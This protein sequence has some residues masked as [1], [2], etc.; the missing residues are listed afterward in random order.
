M[1]EEK[2]DSWLLS[3]YERWSC[4]AMK[5]ELFLADLMMLPFWK[6]LFIDRKISD[7]LKQIVKENP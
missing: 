7:Y 2:L 6:R 4:R 1:D 3:Q 5:D